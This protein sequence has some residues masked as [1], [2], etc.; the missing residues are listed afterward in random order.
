MVSDMTWI[1]FGKKPH[2]WPGPLMKDALDEACW[3][4]SVSGCVTEQKHMGP[5]YM[6][7]HYCAVQCIYRRKLLSNHDISRAGNIWSPSLIWLPS[8]FASCSSVPRFLADLCLITT[9]GD[10]EVQP[11]RVCADGPKS[12]EINFTVSPYWMILSQWFNWACGSE[13]TSNWE[14]CRDA[15]WDNQFSSVGLVIYCIIFEQRC[16]NN[17]CYV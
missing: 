13:I 15:W 12:S 3:W 7:S 17:I 11:L 10:M 9:P 16:K 4:F 2:M 1:E 6:N 8:L 14:Q 5:Y